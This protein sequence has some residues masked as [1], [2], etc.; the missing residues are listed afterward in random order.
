MILLFA[1]AGNQNKLERFSTDADVKRSFERNGIVFQKL[2]E[3]CR[4]PQTRVPLF[5]NLLGSTLQVHGASMARVDLSTGEEITKVDGPG[6]FTPEGYWALYETA[7]EALERGVAG[8]SYREILSAF[9]HGVSAIEAFLGTQVHEWNRTH[10]AQTLVDSKTAKVSFDDKV[11]KWIPI[12]SG[13]KKLDKSGRRW[14]A[15]GRIRA[16]RDGVAVHP[17][18]PGHGVQYSEL[19]IL[20]NLFSSGVSGLLI[21]LH[22]LFS[23][24]I[25]GLII[26]D[27]YA[28]EI[29]LVEDPGTPT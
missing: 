1:K 25:P 11:E 21:D 7:H 27:T 14:Q 16:I 26:R 17:K 18:E 10:P 3:Q 20:G 23:K 4:D 12:I 19:V 29:E 5:E 13:G 28:P 22:L 15:F 24:T 9:V 8:L 6:L 2:V